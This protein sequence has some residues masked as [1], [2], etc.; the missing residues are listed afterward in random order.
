[1]SNLKQIGLGIKQYANMMRWEGWYPANTTDN[2]NT[3]VAAF[4]ILVNTKKLTDTGMYICP[5]ATGKT[6]ST[7]TT[8]P[9]AAT[10]YTK[11]L[12]ADNVSYRYSKYSLSESS[13]ADSAVA[14]DLSGNHTDAGNALFVDG[15]V[16]QFDTIVGGTAWDAAANIGNFDADSTIK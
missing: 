12:T 2:K 9:A 14:A 15:H 10:F 11:P 8:A 1:M 16:G 7:D 5:S 13:A 4:N 3:P 6:K